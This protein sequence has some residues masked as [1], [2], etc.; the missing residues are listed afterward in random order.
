M[1]NTVTELR[2]F[3]LADAGI[4]ALVVDRV[5]SDVLSQGKPSPSIVMTL[6]DGDSIYSTTGLS[7]LGRVKVQLDV[8][9]DTPGNRYTLAELVR[10]RMAAYVGIIGAGYAQGIFLDAS[11]DMYDDAAKQ[12]RRSLDFSVWNEETTT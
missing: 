2:A 11:R 3:L 6:I 5:Y 1:T 12:Y 9:A 7:G 10:L 4:L 8:Y